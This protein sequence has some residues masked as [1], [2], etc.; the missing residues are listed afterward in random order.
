MQAAPEDKKYKAPPLS[1]AKSPDI[2]LSH[3][4]Q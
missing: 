3:T 1:T 2:S 4:N